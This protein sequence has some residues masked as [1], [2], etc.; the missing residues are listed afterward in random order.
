MPLFVVMTLDLHL[1][2]GMMLPRRCSVEENNQKLSQIMEI[3][4]KKNWGKVE[5][6]QMVAAQSYQASGDWT[7]FKLVADS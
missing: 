1:L 5:K 6:L 7:E 4:T 3:Q 2:C